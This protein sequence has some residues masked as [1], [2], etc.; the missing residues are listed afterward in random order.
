MY[1]SYAPESH[2]VEGHSFTANDTT[3]EEETH[4][5]CFDRTIKR[6][7]TGEAFTRLYLV[8][9]GGARTQVNSENQERAFKKGRHTVRI[10]TSQPDT[11]EPGTYKYERV[12]EMELSN[13]RV[14]RTFI[15]ESDEFNITD[16]GSTE[17]PAC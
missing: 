15:F 10:V 9:E 16:S 17:Q 4:I 14:D 11:I 1:A 7:A 6:Q 5:A 12:Y 13:G 2:Y 3:I 8:D